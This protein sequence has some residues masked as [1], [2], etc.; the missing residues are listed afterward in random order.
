MF[1]SYCYCV[2]ICFNLDMQ[3]KNQQL[4]LINKKGKHFNRYIYIKLSKV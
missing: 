1:K 2:L 3:L 4:L